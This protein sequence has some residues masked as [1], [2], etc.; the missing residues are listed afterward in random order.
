MGIKNR[1]DIRIEE[2]LDI[3]LCARIR[4]GGIYVT[5]PECWPHPG[6]KCCQ[7]CELKIMDKVDISLLFLYVAFRCC[8]LQIV[9]EGLL[10]LR[11]NVSLPDAL[12]KLSKTCSETIFGIIECDHIPGV[13]DTEFLHNRKEC[14]KQFCY[15]SPMSCCI[16]MQNMQTRESLSRM[17]D[18]SKDILANKLRIPI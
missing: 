2:L 8:T 11:R 15:P 4:M 13:R 18:M 10:L 7:G 6:E 1:D 16:N 9:E 3:C 17:I 14:F 12:Q 5:H